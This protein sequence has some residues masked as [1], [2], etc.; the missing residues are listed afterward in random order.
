MSPNKPTLIAALFL[1]SCSGNDNVFDE[2]SHASILPDFSC[3]ISKN[4]M[5][6]HGYIDIDGEFVSLNYSLENGYLQNFFWIVNSDTIRELRVEK[7]VPYGGH[8]VKL[9]ITDVFGDTASIS[10]SI[11]VEE[12]FSISLISPVDNFLDLSKGDIVRFQYKINGI[13]E[14]DEPRIYACASAN[15]DRRPAVCNWREVKGD[16][17]KIEGPV[18]WRV[19]V[20]IS[21]INFVYSEIRS[22]CPEV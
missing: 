5:Y 20:G 12:L 15:C 19:G 11:W 3:E 17:L 4:T 14:W 21:G 16:T 8:F 22:I 18:F 1:I 10:D 7:E 13:N 9:F 6:L 2:K